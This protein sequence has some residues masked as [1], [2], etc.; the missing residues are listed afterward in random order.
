M[1]SGH[2]SK[3]ANMENIRSVQSPR[4]LIPALTKLNIGL[5]NEGLTCYINSALQC[6]LN[7]K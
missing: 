7:L 3:Y 1:I 4:I 6:L 5:T 2:W